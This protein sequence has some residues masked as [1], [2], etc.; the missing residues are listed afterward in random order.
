[1][2]D[3]SL[4]A[5]SRMEYA[6]SPRMQKTG[7]GLD[8]LVLIA[9]LFFFVVAL[10]YGGIVFYKGSL[11][12]SLDGLTH[13]L[14]QQEEDLDPKIIGEIARVDRGLA[15]ARSLLA[16]HV[17]TSHL[18]DFLEDNTLEDVYYTNF[19]YGFT[20]GGAVTVSGKASGF[21]ALHQQ[22]EQLRAQPTVSSITLTN[23]QIADAGAVNFGMDFVLNENLFRYR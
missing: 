8:I 23:V 4:I 7:K 19:S 18:F 1:M 21:S 13:E 10:V 9:F 6:G 12:E 5:K 16:Q 15:T 22:L 3:P 17:Y 20:N 2:S 14:A 11:E